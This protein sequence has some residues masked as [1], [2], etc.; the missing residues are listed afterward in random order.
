MQAMRDADQPI[1]SG[2]S[3]QRSNHLR[4]GARL[5]G[6]SPTRG[7]TRSWLAWKFCWLI[8]LG[9]VVIVNMMSLDDGSGILSTVW[10]VGTDRDEIVAVVYLQL[11]HTIRTS[12]GCLEIELPKCSVKMR[13]QTVSQFCRLEIQR[14]RCTDRGS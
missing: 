13:T 6:R 10:D 5:F 11:A 7:S 9:M 1:A 8:V 3:D 4:K 14:G 2:T 12:N